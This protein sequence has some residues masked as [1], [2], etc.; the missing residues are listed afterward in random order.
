[1][2]ALSTIVEESMITM[3]RKGSR[4]QIPIAAPFFVGNK[5]FMFVVNREF[6]QRILIWRVF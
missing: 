5:V 3:V 1:M 6:S 4:V 2:L